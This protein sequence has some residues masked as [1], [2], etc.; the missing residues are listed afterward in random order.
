MSFTQAPAGENFEAYQWKTWAHR[1]VEYTKKNL[2]P[3]YDFFKHP[4]FDKTRSLCRSLP[5]WKESPVKSFMN[6]KYQ[7][8]PVNNDF[9]IISL[10][11]Q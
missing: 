8:V 5:E 4:L 7:Y 9:N 6:C 2:C 10:N 1:Y 3:F 11:P